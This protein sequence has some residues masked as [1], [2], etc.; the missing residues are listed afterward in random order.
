MKLHYVTSDRMETYNPQKIGDL[1][2]SVAKIPIDG[3][4]YEI[5]AD[6]WCQ[7]GVPCDGLIESSKSLFNSRVTNAGARFEPPPES[8]EVSAQED[9]K[10]QKAVPK[11]KKAKKQTQASQQ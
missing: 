10:P 1:G 7:R 2:G 6:L 11:N 4:S 9:P 5:R 8:D 3:G